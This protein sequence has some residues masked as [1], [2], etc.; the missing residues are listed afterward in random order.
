MLQAL[1]FFNYFTFYLHFVSSPFCY[2]T[3]QV[4]WGF[5]PRVQQVII[6]DLLQLSILSPKCVRIF[7]LPC[8]HTGPSYLI[9]QWK[10]KPCDSQNVSAGKHSHFLG[11]QWHWK[12]VIWKRCRAIPA[13]KWKGS[14]FMLLWL[15]LWQIILLTVRLLSAQ[16]WLN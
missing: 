14:L 11:K 6:I 10:Q 7:T 5:P 13:W 8:S 12:K 16:V 15:S 4:L 2:H 1:V 3:E 9:C